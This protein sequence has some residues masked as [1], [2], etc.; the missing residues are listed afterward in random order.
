MMRHCLLHYGSHGTST[1]TFGTA[2]LR[3]YRKVSPAS[4]P[5]SNVLSNS[6]PEQWF[7]E[8]HDVAKQ[9]HAQARHIVR[10]TTGLSRGTKLRFGDN[11]TSSFVDIFSLFSLPQYQSLEELG[12]VVKTKQIKCF[13]WS[14][15]DDPQQIPYS[16]ESTFPAIFPPFCI[17]P[18]LGRLRGD[19]RPSDFKRAQ[20]N[21]VITAARKGE[22]PFEE[23]C[24]AVGIY[25]DYDLDLLCRCLLPMLH[26]SLHLP[27]HP[28]NWEVHCCQTKL[29]HN[30]ESIFPSLT[31]HTRFKLLAVLS[32]LDKK[33]LEVSLT[34]LK[35]PPSSMWGV[36]PPWSEQYV[37][38]SYLSC[39]CNCLE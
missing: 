2:T 5:D 34:S 3:Y 6:G 9:F 32:I 30:L 21:L 27:G 18:D 20:T 8:M 4:A 11:N 23:H 24:L 38:P 31:S 37:T 39:S 36:L 16:W 19:L 10:I 14:E 7:I 33:P 13:V 29:P 15:G 22:N 1:L 25:D 26:S 12:R 28:Q 17:H 35:G